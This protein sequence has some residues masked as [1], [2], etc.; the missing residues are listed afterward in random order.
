MIRLAHFSDIHITAHPL[1]WRP[2]DWFNKRLTGWINCACLGRGH[3]FNQADAV[4]A[5]LV[6]DLH[7]RRH[8]RV[9]F[10]G[11]ATALGFASEFARAAAILK[12]D[13]VPPLP[14]LAVPGNHDYY[15]RHSATYGNFE[16]NFASW[17]VGERVDG[18]HYP[19]AQKVGEIWLIAVNSAIGNFWAWD[20]S[21]RVDD[22]QL[23]RLERL[24]ARLSPGP[25]ILVTHFP[26]CLAN[27][28]AERPIHGL[29]NMD[30]AVKVAAAGG[31]GLWLHGHRH[32]PYCL[33]RPSQAPFPVICAGSATQTGVWSYGEYEIEGNALRAMRRVYSPK[34]GVF[35]DGEKF[36]VLIAN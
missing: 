16:R 15:T 1:G 34:Q 20:A 19:F 11:D 25:R 2:E 36:N 35:A 23:N 26:I 13:A 3:R 27:G 8:D 21:G 29:R 32:H 30:A 33:E 22:E 28:N 14:G 9:I 10:S 12:L 4:L 18:A 5:A 7:A 31:V 24:L 6:A 17:Q